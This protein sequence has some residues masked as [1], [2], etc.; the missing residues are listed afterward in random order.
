MK[1]TQKNVAQTS[2][3]LRKAFHQDIDK[4]FDTIDERIRNYFNTG[5]KNINDQIKGIMAKMKTCVDLAA[6]MDKLMAHDGSKLLAQAEK[7]LDEAKQISQSLTDSSVDVVTLPRLR[8]KTKQGWR[9]QEGTVNLQQGIAK[10]SIWV[11]VVIL[12]L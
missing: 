10:R 1:A 3:E 7:L 2:K 12:F 5:M 8:L 9:L 11:R 4:Y 6:K